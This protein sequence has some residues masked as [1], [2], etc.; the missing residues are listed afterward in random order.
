M[1]T[2]HL[3]GPEA[4]PSSAAVYASGLGDAQDGR[5]EVRDEHREAG[6]PG[7]A[8]NQSGARPNCDCQ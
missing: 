1:P 6:G 8:G 2:V 5:A 3:C 7:L 4:E